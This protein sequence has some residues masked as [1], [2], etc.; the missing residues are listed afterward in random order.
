MAVFNLRLNLVK[1]LVGHLLLSK[2]HCQQPVVVNERTNDNSKDSDG[3]ADD[4]NP[5]LGGQ[6]NN[7]VFVFGGHCQCQSKSGVGPFEP[8]PVILLLSGCTPR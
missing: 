1:P 8:T 5:V 6:A 3:D 7:N 2:K 4:W